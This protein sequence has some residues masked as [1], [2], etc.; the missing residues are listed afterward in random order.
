M[1]SISFINSFVHD[2]RYEKVI[3]DFVLYTVTFKVISHKTK[4]TF[5]AIIMA[6]PFK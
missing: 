5:I 1:I 4:L 6:Y 2:W 3:Q